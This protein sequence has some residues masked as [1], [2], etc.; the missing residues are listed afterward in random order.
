MTTETLRTIEL[1]A[2]HRLLL[3]QAQECLE[4][5]ARLQEGLERVA[6]QLETA[7]A[8]A[9]WTAPDDHPAKELLEREQTRREL[10]VKRLRGQLT[11]GHRLLRRA[12]RGDGQDEPGEP[13]QEMAPVRAGT[14]GRTEALQQAQRDADDT[15]GVAVTYVRTIV[16]PETRTLWEHRWEL[17]QAQLTSAGVPSGYLAV[18]EQLWGWWTAALNDAGLV[19]DAPKEGEKVDFDRHEVAG[20]EVIGE[21][22]AAHWHER[23][24][25]VMAPGICWR[26][27]NLLLAYPRVVTGLYRPDAEPRPA[28]TEESEQAASTAD[29]E[30][31]AASDEDAPCPA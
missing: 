21:P 24:T 30:Q 22:A 1:L 4:L 6:C 16:V 20:T 19:L 3:M 13:G 8:V 26:Q 12:V 25:R 28:P 29:E 18:R 15:Y 10:V 31:P 7:L 5:M 23:I 11:F 9:S 14:E 27:R 17:Q 2:E